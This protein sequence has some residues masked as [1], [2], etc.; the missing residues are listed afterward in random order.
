MS[1][2]CVNYMSGHIDTKYLD[3]ASWIYDRMAASQRL[4]LSR[5]QQWNCP[6]DKKSTRVVIWA[7]VFYFFLKFGKSDHSDFNG[8]QNLAGIC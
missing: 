3:Q 2:D 4:K 7:V 8:F 6:V 1:S 5:P